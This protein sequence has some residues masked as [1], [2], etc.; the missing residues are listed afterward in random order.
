MNGKASPPII[1]LPS[2]ALLFPV[3]KTQEF[4]RVRRQIGNVIEFPLKRGKILPFLKRRGH[5]E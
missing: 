3:W 4:G 2:G 5:R 1:K